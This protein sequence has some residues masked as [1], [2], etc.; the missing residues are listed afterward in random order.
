MNMTIAY[1]IAG[2]LLI[3]AGRRIFWLFLGLLCFVAGM[4]A[5]Q[6]WFPE[7]SQ[8][9]LL[10]AAVGI[11]ALGA[12]IG[13][14]AQK[15]AVWIGGFFGGGLLALMLVHMLTESSGSTTLVAF[16]VG[17]VIGILLA[18]FLFKWV[19]IVVSSAIGALV[20]S[21]VLETGMALGSIVF[22]VLLLAGVIIQGG[23][24]WHRKS[25]SGPESEAKSSG[26]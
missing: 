8:S 12:G 6:R 11:G 16:L 14:M 24:L 26:A 4:S 22:V 13:A 21:K 3:V 9:T 1:I 18:H 10:L 17:G 7:V 20:I 15:I 2:A 5:L 19:M 25:G 23:F